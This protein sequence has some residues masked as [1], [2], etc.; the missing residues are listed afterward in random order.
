[1]RKLRKSLCCILL[2]VATAAP[3]AAQAGDDVLAVVIYDRTG[4]VS[5]SAQYTED[6]LWQ[7]RQDA[8]AALIEHLKTQYGESAP[9]LGFAVYRSGWPQQTYADLIDGDP[10]PTPVLIS[11]L[12]S[13]VEPY[14]AVG[15]QEAN[16]LRE[17]QELL[18]TVD[19]SFASNRFRR[20]NA[21]PRLAPAV[22]LVNAAT[23]GVLASRRP[24]RVELYTI[25]S[26]GFWAGRR[27]TEVPGVLNRYQTELHD[28]QVLTGYL[29]HKE[30]GFVGRR[31]EAGVRL[32]RYRVEV[33]A[34]PSLTFAGRVVERA[35]VNPLLI[36]LDEWESASEHAFEI[37]ESE[38]T[39]TSYRVMS[40]LGAQEGTT[41][42]WIDF[43][44][45][46]VHFDPMI[47]QLAELGHDA[48]QAEARYQIMLRGQLGVA[49][50][51][52]NVR[53]PVELSYEVPFSIALDKPSIV[54]QY[55]LWILTLLSVAAVAGCYLLLRVRS[56]SKEEQRLRQE[57][58]KVET[59]AN[60][61]I[62]MGPAIYLADSIVQQ[63]RSARVKPQRV[64]VLADRPLADFKPF[65]VSFPLYDEDLLKFQYSIETSC[66]NGLVDVELDQIPSEDSL[67]LELSLS[68]PATWDELGKECEPLE[69]RFKTRLS[70]ESFAASHQGT[71]ADEYQLRLGLYPI[72]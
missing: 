67:D 33:S 56:Q 5:G 12:E 68:L 9:G 8:V 18:D 32:D 28:L 65:T 61:L 36:R 47:A 42:R 10:L 51:I 38:V 6:D 44:D 49:A 43:G 29:Q 19:R 2:G 45:N 72:L 52:A 3:L 50:D 31:G 4:A 34:R 21:D 54:E 23:S 55:G 11:T 15:S 30:I 66:D 62:K 59:I 20:S 22:A 60:R 7:L 64:N 27:A 13:L 57:V 70:F 35:Q 26:A 25:R 16:D 69:L 14:P 63:R 17:L 1:M 53:L 58:E 39:W 48:E 37:A 24:G 41:G 40:Q 71:L 46:R